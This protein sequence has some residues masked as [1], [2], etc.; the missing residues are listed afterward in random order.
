MD[1]QVGAR[2]VCVQL[3]VGVGKV[4]PIDFGTSGDAPSGNIR[5]SLAPD[6]TRK[7]REVGSGLSR[8]LDSVRDVEVSGL[9]RVLPSNRRFET[10]E[11]GKV[12]VTYRYLPK[13]NAGCNKVHVRKM[14]GEN[15]G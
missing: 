3:N 1:V 12:S 15:V 4:L 10:V 9:L 2:I 7:R 13:R 8:S 14:D 5:R 11:T 6:G